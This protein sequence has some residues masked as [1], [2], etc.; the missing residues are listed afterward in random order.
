M[1]RE[2]MESRINLFKKFSCEEKKISRI[3]VAK[4]NEGARVM[5]QW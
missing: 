2:Q 5:A 1:N 4:V 3:V